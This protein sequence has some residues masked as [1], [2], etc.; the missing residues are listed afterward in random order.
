[1]RL[2]ELIDTIESYGVI[3]IKR[4]FT[5]NTLYKGTGFDIN[6][7]NLPDAEVGLIKTRNDI[8]Y[9]YI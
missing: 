1:M 7:Q 6:W 5:E 9:I 8:I 2:M 4:R 3:C